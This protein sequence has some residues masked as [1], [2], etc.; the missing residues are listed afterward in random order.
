[1]KR[2]A[3]RERTIGGTG[4]TQRRLVRS[5]AGA[6]ARRGD[7]AKMPDRRLAAALGALTGGVGL[8]AMV[9]L[10]SG[11]FSGGMTGFAWIA[12]L[13][14]MVPWIGYVAWRAGHGRLSASR[15][16]VVLTLSLVGLFAVWILTIGPVVALACSLA[17]FGVIW[18]SDWPPRHPRGE[19]DFVRI[20]ELQTEDLD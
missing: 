17:A 9:R 19:E 3:S 15:A 1:M 14:A 8:I 20:E 5:A 12:T 7:V 2:R 16:L 6:N 11:A 4:I 18:V 10:V 13:V